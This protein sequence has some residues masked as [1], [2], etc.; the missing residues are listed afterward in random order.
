[1]EEKT[2]TKSRGE[3]FG[4]ASRYE[5]VERFFRANPR[6]TNS[7]AAKALGCDPRTVR[8]HLEKMA[9]SGIAKVRHPRVADNYWTARIGRVVVFKEEGEDTEDGE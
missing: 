9:V 5:D 7:E 6:A 2:E 8:R 3:G 1:M 4:F